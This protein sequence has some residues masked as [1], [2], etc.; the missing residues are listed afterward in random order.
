ML[1]SYV[2]I[3]GKSFS[4]PNYR[5]NLI[6]LFISKFM[7]AKSMDSRFCKGSKQPLFGTPEIIPFICK[8]L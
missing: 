8:K 2:H 7:I 6:I 3:D 5:I 1:M 4:M